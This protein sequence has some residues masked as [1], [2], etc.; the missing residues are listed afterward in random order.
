M[1]KMHTPCF[2]FDEKAFRKNIDDYQKILNDSFSKSIIGYSFKTNSLPYIIR[3]AKDCGCYAEV[4]SDTEY[5]LAKYAGYDAQHIIFNGPVKGKQQ[6]IA[7]FKE[8]SIINIDSWAEVG[9]LEELSQEG[10][11]GTIGIRVNIDLESILPGQTATGADGGRFGFCDE[12]GQLAAVIQKIKN[13]QGI[14]IGGFHM[15]VSNKSKSVDVYRVLT[16]KACD[17]AAREQLD[18]K[19]L[20]IGGGFFGGGDNGAAYKTYVDAICSALKGKCMS[21]VELIVEPGASVIAM[22]VDYVTEVKDI[23]DSLRGR[24]VVTNGSR[25]HIDPFFHKIKYEYS[26]ISNES[27][28][29]EKQVIC[30]FT[31]MEYDRFMRVRDETELHVGDQIIYHIVGS[32]TMCFNPLFIEYLPAVYTKRDGEYI[33]VRA[34]WGVQE[35]IQKCKW[36]VEK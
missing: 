5:Q 28:R 34:Q 14:Q 20:D 31:C 16:E 10:V 6:F 22:A 27:N 7:A 21:A 30:G 25:M 32:Y 3:V 23:K 17:I 36:D 33:M 24:F 8:G 19:Y 13:M 9:W 35:Y 18:L 1:N 15:H 4:V 12:N 2:I 26:V 29:C 11:S